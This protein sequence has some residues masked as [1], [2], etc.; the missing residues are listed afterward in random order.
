M[1]KTGI[2]KSRGRAQSVLEYVMIIVCAVLAL[3]TMTK[4]L[5]LSVQGKLRQSA[6]EIG[7][8]YNPRHTQGSH[9]LV[10]KSKSV[11]EVKALS[12]AELN[13]LSYPEHYPYDLNENGD[14][15]EDDVFGTTTNSTILYGNS[16]NTRSE[17]ILQ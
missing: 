5:K 3:L 16:T 2:L 11:T 13:A 12:E 10:I 6:D 4:Y 7:E 15:N 1:A 14:P 9:T 17:E 8:H